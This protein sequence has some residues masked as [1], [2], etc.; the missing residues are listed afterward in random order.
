MATWE[1]AGGLVTGPLEHDGPGAQEAAAEG[2]V[3]LL[4]RKGGIAAAA[5]SPGLPSSGMSGM[6]SV[7]TPR[8]QEEARGGPAECGAAAGPPCS[9]PPQTGVAPLAAALL[10]ELSRHLPPAD[11]IPVPSGSG[12][13]EGYLVVR[14][15]NGRLPVPQRQAQGQQAAAAP[16]A[17]AQPAAAAA[18]TAE[19][20]Q[21][22]LQQLRALRLL[23]AVRTTLLQQQAAQQAAAAA[24]QAQAGAGGGLAA[25]ILLAAAASVAAAAAVPQQSPLDPS[26]ATDPQLQHPPLQPL[27]P[28]A[29]LQ[30]PAAPP[31]QPATAQQRPPLWKPRP[32]KRP[33][34]V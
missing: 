16:A 5:P 26:A 30:Q 3:K 2:L 19:R 1:A 23:V 33:R 21:R 22:Y 29:Q 24:A 6:Q 11:I 17:P 25:S 9:T 18:W 7:G 28:A 4:C 32:V 13:T 34:Q 10:H 27:Q 8:R 15:L 12:T 31:Q 20:E 14:R